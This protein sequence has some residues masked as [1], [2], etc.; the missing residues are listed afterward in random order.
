MSPK[1]IK[2]LLALLVC[3][4]QAA[5][6]QET[7]TDS[8]GWGFSVGAFFA[9]QDMKTEFEVTVGEIDVIVDFEDDLGLR[10]SQSVFRFAAFY[11]FNERHRMDF[12]VFD[13]S[14]SAVVTLSR[15]IE[16][17]DVVY[18][19]SAEVSTGLDLTIYKAAYTYS[20]LRR[21]KLKLGV[22]GGLYVADI[23]LQLNLLGSDEE[24][25]GDI[26]APLPVFG[27]RGEYFFSDR[28]RASASAEWFGLQIDDYEGT[29]RDFLIGVDYRF[30]NHAAVGLGYN[31]VRMDIDATEGD[32][33][34]DL[35]WN[36]S[37]FIGY[38]R[39]S[40]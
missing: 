4:P 35:V 13:L 6:S 9:D 29:L 11:D 16:W 17:G 28:W 12:D 38:L 27:L 25:R 22:T 36:Y 33:R 30:G 18:P 14:Q 15:E 37:G 2:Y 39:F 24:E 23:G 20:M 3:S 34:A 40:F 21:E 26:T 8:S 1:S 5:F 31:D 19:I 32:L 7:D 10:D